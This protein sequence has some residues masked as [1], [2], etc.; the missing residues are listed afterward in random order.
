MS[1]R[2][3]KISMQ[4]D[5]D[6]PAFNI[7]HRGIRFNDKDALVN[8]YR[9]PKEWGWKAPPG[10]DYPAF[11]IDSYRADPTTWKPKD[12]RWIEGTFRGA[13]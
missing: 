13:R 7:V 2:W 12:K 10:T 9:Y 8:V 11:K 4:P 6:D 5:S 1:R 3:A